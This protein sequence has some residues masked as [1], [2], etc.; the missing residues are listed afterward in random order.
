M[1]ERDRR[2]PRAARGGTPEFAIDFEGRWLHR[3]TPIRR[4]AM[5]RLFAGMLRRER[6]AY[7]LVTPQQRVRVEVADA[8]FL[9]V[10]FERNG[11]TF[12]FVTNLGERYA[13]DETHP[14]R[15]QPAADGGGVRA[16]QELR[17]GISARIARAAFYRLAECAVTEPGGS[18]Y[19]VY[20]A[21]R[22]FALE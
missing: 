12:V 22:F 2:S 13:L 9:I 19:G 15:L 20:S 18:R 11:D 17:D 21:G 3:G 4:E 14:L 5:V 10:D 6:G 16:Y 8:P 1:T 7:V